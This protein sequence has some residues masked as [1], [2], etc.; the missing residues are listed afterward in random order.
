MA[1]PLSEKPFQLYWKNKAQTRTKNEKRAEGETILPGPQSPQLDA[2]RLV[3]LYP[4][5]FILVHADIYC[6]HLS[7]LLEYL[8]GGDGSARR[9]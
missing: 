3:P 1:F 5:G 7:D 9:L 8:L 6:I 4:I 2:P